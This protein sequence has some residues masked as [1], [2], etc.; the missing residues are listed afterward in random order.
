MAS[1]TETT[2]ELI[3]VTINGIPADLLKQ[4]DD[5]AEKDHRSRSS[6]LRLQLEDIIARKAGPK[7]A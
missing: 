5:L 4:I 7:A 6:F 3:T 2:D 1:E